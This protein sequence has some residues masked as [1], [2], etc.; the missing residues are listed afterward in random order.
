MAKLGVDVDVLGGIHANESKAKV[1]TI[2]E[3]KRKLE[4][5]HSPLEVFYIISFPFVSFFLN[6]FFKF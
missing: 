6:F 5:E 2:S 1:S 3:K 4:I